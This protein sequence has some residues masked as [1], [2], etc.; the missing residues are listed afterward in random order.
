MQQG[1]QG[2]RRPAGAV[3]AA[4]HA[5]KIAAGE[6]A[7]TGCDRPAKRKGAAAAAARWAGDGA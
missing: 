2:R 6:I 5:M 1:P 4:V 7:E 3:G